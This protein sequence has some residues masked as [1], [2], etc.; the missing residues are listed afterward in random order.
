M[1]VKQIRNA[2]AAHRPHQLSVPYPDAAVL[3]LV[4]DD[5]N[6]HVVLTKRASGLS[7][8]SGQ[9]AFPGGMK[10]PGDPSLEYTAL[11]E[12]REEISV[13][14][15]QITLCGQLSQVISKHKIRVTPFVGVIPPDLEFVPEP[16]E[17][18][19]IFTVPLRFFC[20]TPPVRQDKVNFMGWQLL[21]P[22]WD[23]G[24]YHIWGLSAL[25]LADFLWKVEKVRVGGVVGE[26]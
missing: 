6:P 4:T 26:A 24:Q 20:E 17:L 2:L 1:V 3:V 10:D 5:I 21:M 7:T 14:S 18:E 23:Y 12:A 9:V 13:S 22:A 8:H 11:R 15:D 19:S 16:G 25:I